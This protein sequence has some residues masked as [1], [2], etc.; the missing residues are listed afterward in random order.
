MVDF[1][2]FGGLRYRPE[3][4]GDLASVLAPPFD[5]IDADE[6]AALHERSP[7]NIVRLELAQG[8][9]PYA[10]AAA[11]LDEWRRAGVLAQDGEPAFY[12][13]GQEFEHEGKRHRRTGLLGRLRLEPWEHGSVRPHEETMRA[14]KEDRLQLLR[15]VRANV[16]PIFALYRDPAGR[17]ARLLPRDERLEVDA[18]TPDGQRHELF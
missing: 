11:Q 13:Y 15:H 6:Q 12:V 7:Y 3:A 10:R 4:A 2:P 8:A 17:V 18:T 16:S 14:P 9:D 1:R 5:V